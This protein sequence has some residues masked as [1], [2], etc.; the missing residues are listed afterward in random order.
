LSRALG[1]QAG[2][3]TICSTDVPAQFSPLAERFLGEK[4]KAIQRVAVG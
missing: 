4:I 2:Q 1:R 3:T